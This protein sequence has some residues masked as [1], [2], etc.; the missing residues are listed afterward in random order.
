MK[1]GILA[2]AILVGIIN[3]GY[4]QTEETLGQVI[5]RLTYQWDTEA[6]TLE[7][8]GGLTSF[9]KDVEYRTTIISLMDEIHHYD[10]VLYEKAK[11]AHQRSHDHEIVKLIKEIESFE[12]GYGP[13]NFI[14]FLKE[15]CDGQKA[16]EKQSEDLK[17]AMGE[18]SYDGQAYVIEV[19]MRRYVKHLTKRVDNI[20]KHVHHLHI[21]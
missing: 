20:R 10:S 15:E 16:L 3:L 17:T 14:H 1:R 7:T 13:K 9:C 21:K 12:T 18:E 4:S 2:I 19:E 6:L 5:D 8:Y 11:I